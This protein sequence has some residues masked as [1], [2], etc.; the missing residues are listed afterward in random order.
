MTGLRGIEVPCVRT[1]DPAPLLEA[2]GAATPI[3]VRGLIDAWDARRWT[4]D[5]LSAAAPERP[6]T[7]LVD[8]PRNGGVLPGGQKSY[9]QEMTVAE[10]LAH[11]SRRDLERPCYLGYSRPSELIPGYEQAFDFGP[12]TVPSTA[13]TDTRLWVGSSGTCSGLHSDLKDNVFAQIHGTKR[14]LLVPLRQTH[15]VY[16]FIDNIVN[17]MV[18]PEDVDVDRFPR[19]LRATAY[20]T[21]VEPGDVLYIPRGWWHHLRSTSPSISINHWFGPEIPAR[22]FLA[23]LARLGPR[24]VGRTVADMVRYSVLK[25]QYEKDFFFTPAST[26]ERLF[27]L[28]RHGNFSRENDPATDDAVA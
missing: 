3:K 27:D 20:E 9:E 7:V 12:I 22:V 26:G 24:Y 6:V 17:S 13:S 10:F 25:R 11:A 28:L 8:L 23:L 19:I 14:V 18:D 4:F 1:G 21:V 15:L 16:P 2:I 5:S